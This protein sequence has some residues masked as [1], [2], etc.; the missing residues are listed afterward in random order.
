MTRIIFG[1][2]M[3]VGRATIFLV[4]LAVILA[5]TVGLASAALAGT[6]VGA[7]FN[8]GKT[9]TVNALTSLVGSVAGP[10]LTIDNNSPVAGAT[11][12]RLEVEPGKPPMTVNS[13]AEVHGLNVDSLDGRNSSDF[14]QESSD[15]DDFLPRSIYVNQAQKSV[16][17]N[18]IRS[19][20]ISC[21]PGDV[22][23]GG[24]FNE[25]NVPNSRVTSSFMKEFTGDTSWVVEV[26]NDNPVTTEIYLITA[27]CAD[28]PPLRPQG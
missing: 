19:D 16:P 13:T 3:W 14:L 28:Y 2:V 21:D 5:L 24:G 15:R 22:A 25:V 4:G 20:S 8:L 10:A 1:K 7:T 27:V 17:T 11:A 6:G 18:S 23:T 12:L 9:N 26:H